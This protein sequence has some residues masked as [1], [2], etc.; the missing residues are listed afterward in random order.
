MSRSKIEAITPYW[1]TKDLEYSLHLHQDDETEEWHVGI[2]A[3]VNGGEVYDNFLDAL[4]DF[5]LGVA[6]LRLEELGKEG[7]YAADWV[8]GKVT[9]DQIPDELKYA[10][11]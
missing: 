5:T 10:D 9:L 3:P 6:Q 7:F 8:D 1:E 2:S 11:S 4:R